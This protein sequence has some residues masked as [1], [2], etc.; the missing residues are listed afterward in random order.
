MPVASNGGSV[1]LDL[2][3][4]A[5]DNASAS[6]NNAFDPGGNVWERTEELH[7]SKNFRGLRG[8]RFCNR[9]L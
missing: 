2:K 5:S 6:P 4:G 3:V 1:V 9:C 8:A 7:V